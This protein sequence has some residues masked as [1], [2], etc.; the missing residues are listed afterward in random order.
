MIHPY[1]KPRPHRDVGWLLDP[2]FVLGES[3]PVPIGAALDAGWSLWAPS[4]R[5]RQLVR[6]GHGSC[7]LWRYQAIGWSPVQLESKFPVRGLQVDCPTDPDE[8]LGGLVAWRDWLE[9]HGA[10]PAGSLG[11]SGLS[12]LKAT[13]R[14]PLWTSVGDVPPITWTLGGRQQDAGPRPAHYHTPVSHYDIQA[15][16]A[17][18]LG[19]VRYGGRWIQVHPAFADNLIGRMADKGHM[20][21]VRARVRVPA[22]LPWWAGPLP[23]RARKQPVGAHELLDSIADNPYPVGRTV[24]GCWSYPE[25][26]EADL[27]GCKIKLLGAWVHSSAQRPFV[28]WWEA[29]MQGRQLPGFAGLLAK[30]TGNATWG[31]FALSAEGQRVIEPGSRP[32]P[33]VGGNPS[34]RAHDLGEWITGSIRASLYQGMT[35]AGD[36]LISAHTDGLWQQGKSWIGWRRTRWAD[37]L[38]SINPQVLAYRSHGSPWRYTVAGALDP[39]DFFESKWQRLDERHLIHHLG[40]EAHDRSAA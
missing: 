17:S 29:I 9:S 4:E 36:K 32:V 38:R 10:A 31:Q 39:A 15:A 33:L 7:L 25:I 20:V 28:P 22:H 27:A 37:E 14:R 2:D 11:G 21:F 34:Q 26:V 8:A 23:R 35:I 13:L 18:R 3:G 40:G 12:L 24:Q 16:Y 19:S 5:L 1:A 30:A 6:A